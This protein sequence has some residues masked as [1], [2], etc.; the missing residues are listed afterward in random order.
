[1]LVRLIHTVSVQW[2][3]SEGSLLCLLFGVPYYAGLFKGSLLCCPVLVPQILGTGKPPWTMKR[4][5]AHW[6]SSV[7]GPANTMF[8]KSSL[9]TGGHRGIAD[10]RTADA[11]SDEGATCSCYPVCFSCY[12]SCY[13]LL[14]PWPLAPN[15]S[16]TN[17][18]F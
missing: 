17:V 18:Q 3:F 6:W 11:T 12:Y 16:L 8:S 4:S 15:S 10:I 5:E 7:S 13:M 14:Q 2:W 9:G 1:M